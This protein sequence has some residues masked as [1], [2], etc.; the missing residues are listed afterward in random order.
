MADD[1]MARVR[2]QLEDVLQ[3]LDAMQPDRAS[4]ALETLADPAQQLV[5]ARNDVIA[6]QRANA[7]LVPPDLL[8][9]LNCFASVMA[10]LEYP[11]GGIHWPRIES[12]RKEIRGLADAMAPG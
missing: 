7:A 8:Q 6:A 12:L 2:R 3:A 11:L 5:K 9:R 4:N 10:G 1:T